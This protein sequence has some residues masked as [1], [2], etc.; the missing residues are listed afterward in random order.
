M[1]KVEQYGYVFKI[2]IGDGKRGGYRAD[3]LD[4]VKLALEHY[5]PP[6][7]LWHATPKAGCP[8]CPA[9]EP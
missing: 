7:Q 9:V 8:L 2:S 4:Q 5:Y 1:F 6:G 3:G